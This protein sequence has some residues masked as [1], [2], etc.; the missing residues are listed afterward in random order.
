MNDNSVRGTKKEE[1]GKK[2]KTT[3]W[4]ED[5]DNQ[6]AFRSDIDPSC[7]SGW[8]GDS[9]RGREE[10]RR[11]ST[12]TLGHRRRSVPIPP[13]VRLFLSFP[14]RT[15]PALFPSHSITPF[16]LLRP[17]K[18]EWWWEIQMHRQPRSIGV[19][20]VAYSTKSGVKKMMMMLM[21]MMMVRLP[22]MGLFFFSVSVS[23]VSL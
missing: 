16:C 12:G 18:R 1:E 3:N 2:R 23:V 17:R 14:E 10:K 6:A 11:T 13:P 8:A 9:G 19:V 15:I 22:K 20:P 7:R 21:M 5:D 4:L